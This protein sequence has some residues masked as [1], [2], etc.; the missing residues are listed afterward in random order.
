VFKV[1]SEGARDGIALR[2]SVEIGQTSTEGIEIKKG[3]NVGERIITA[4]IKHL[5]DGLKIKI[6]E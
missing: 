6:A 4:G 2:R 1:V 5:Q 3:L